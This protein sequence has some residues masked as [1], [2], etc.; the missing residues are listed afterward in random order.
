MLITMPTG[1]QCV[2]V[3]NMQETMQEAAVAQV[4]FGVFDQSFHGI[5][6]IRGNLSPEKPAVG[7]LKIVTRGGLG[8]TGRATI[9]MFSGD[10]NL[11]NAPQGR[12]RLAQGPCPW[13]VGPNR[14]RAPQRGAGERGVPTAPAPCLATPA[15]LRGARGRCPAI[16]GA[17][18]PG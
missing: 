8:Y 3:G 10:L 14:S 9:F 4:S 13:V 6:V 17:R 11:L 16:P 12:R 1:Q 18:P 15:P 2:P 7:N 5:M